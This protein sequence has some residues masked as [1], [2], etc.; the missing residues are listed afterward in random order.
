METLAN[1]AENSKS[2]N[3]GFLFLWKSVSNISICWV[4]S[5]IAANMLS[6]KLL[7]GFCPWSLVVIEMCKSPS[8]F[9]LKSNNELSPNCHPSAP[10]VS[11]HVVI[12]YQPALLCGVWGKSRLW[13]KWVWQMIYRSELL[14]LVPRKIPK[15]M[16]NR[17]VKQGNMPI[18]HYHYHCLFWQLTLN[19]DNNHRYLIAGM[20]FHRR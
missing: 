1:A 8:D 15:F 13:H 17:S 10:A 18:L 5:W 16:Q 20:P 14:L 11:Q 19:I 9:E 2:E 6:W 4:D 12:V 3:V 7:R